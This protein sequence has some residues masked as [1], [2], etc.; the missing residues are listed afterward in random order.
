M[1][2]AGKRLSN[3]EVSFIVCLHRDDTL[4]FQDNIL[5]LK[6]FV[7]VTFRGGM[8]IRFFCMIN[9]YYGV[10]AVLKMQRNWVLV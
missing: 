8:N 10:G 4:R 2:S 5:R 7:D 6:F 3:P 9:N 1:Y